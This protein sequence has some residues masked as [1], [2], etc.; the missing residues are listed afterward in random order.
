MFPSSSPQQTATSQ[1]LSYNRTTPPA[2]QGGQGQVLGWLDPEKASDFGPFL[3]ISSPHTVSPPPPPGQGTASP[4]P[5]SHFSA[6]PTHGT[7]ET[8]IAPPH[9]LAETMVQ[10]HFFIS[11]QGQQ[12]LLQFDTSG[13]GFTVKQSPVYGSCTG[14]EGNVAALVAAAGGMPPQSMIFQQGIELA[15]TSGQWTT[16]VFNTP[17]YGPVHLEAGSSTV[18]PKQEPVPEAGF[19][20]G[21]GLAEYNQ[22]TSKGHEIL[23]QAYQSSPI[24]FKLVPVKQRKYPNRPSKTPVHERP[25]ACP[26]EACDRRFSRS[27]ELTRHIRIHTG[28]KPFQCR[29][30]MRS[31]SRS[32]HLTTHIRTHTGEKPFSCDLCGRRFARSDEKKRHTKVHLKQ[33]QKR[34]ATQAQ[35]SE[36]AG[37]SSRSELSQ[38]DPSSSLVP[39]SSFSPS[40]TVSVTTSALQ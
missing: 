1:S 38:D 34:S 5:S 10:E 39:S 30:C 2:Q 18:F 16:P 28:Q 29:I 24:P 31:F 27:D 15:S 8:I 4:A 9:P 12:E 25:Y 21:Q 22:A 3:N 17:D 14:P 13:Q 11:P 19:L 33:K 6:S 20:P 7:F 32:D 37:P 36:G 35:A 26:L 40:E 23:S